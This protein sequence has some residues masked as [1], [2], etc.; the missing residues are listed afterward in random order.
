MFENR[1][2]WITPV[3]AAVAAAAVLAGCSSSASGPFETDAAVFATDPAAN[4][5]GVAEAESPP[6]EVAS[7][8]LD[9]D[10]SVD[11]SDAGSQEAAPPESAAEPPE[12]AA[13]PTDDPAAEPTD[14]PVDESAPASM[15]TET[16]DAVVPAG[17]SVTVVHV[18]DGD[19]VYTSDGGKIRLI[20]YD[21][22]EKGECGFDD[23]KAYVAK[24]VLDKTVTL[25]N[26]AGVDDADRYDRWLRYVYVDGQDLGA[27]VLGAGLAHARYDGLDGYDAHPNQ[28][29][30][31]RID[32]ETPHMCGEN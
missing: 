29:E 31:R 13:E 32:D 30:Y 6:A 28:N 8:A 19:T 10:D 20:G 15:P 5:E 23:A 14:D 21:T 9:G 11:G 7:D 1:Q 24:L 3:M 12:S 16:A 27:S 22:P 17:D 4:P 25:V 18:V 26:P 2:R